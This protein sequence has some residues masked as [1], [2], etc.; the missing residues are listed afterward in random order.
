MQAGNNDIIIILNWEIENTNAQN[1]QEVG[2]EEAGNE[3]VTSKCKT[4]TR[5]V[6]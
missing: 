2:I 3:A 6:E 4:R 1:H 5:K